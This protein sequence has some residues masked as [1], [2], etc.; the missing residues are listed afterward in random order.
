MDDFDK[1]NPEPDLQNLLMHNT[2]QLLGDVMLN[3]LLESLA[4]GVVIINE[5]GRIVLINKRFAQLTGYGKQEVIGQSLSIF[6]PEGMDQKHEQDISDYFA[7]PRIRPLG[8]DLNLIA[9]R[10]D[11]SVFPVEISLSHL[12]TGTED[13]G[14]AFITDISARKKAEEELLTRNQELDAYARNVAHDLN[15]PLA[16]LINFSDLLLDSDFEIS[17]EERKHYLEI[18]AEDSRKMSSIIKELLIFATIKKEDIRLSTVHMKEP[19][20]NVISR[21]RFQIEQKSVQLK[22]DKNICD[23]SGYGPWIEEVWFNYISNAIRYGGTPPLIE[24]GSE[25]QNSD[26][27]KYFVKDNGSGVSTEFKEI[28]FQ[29]NNPE[30]D[31]AAHGYGLGLSIV[32]SIVEKLGGYVAVESIEGNGSIFSFYLKKAS[33]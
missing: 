5:R 33:V 2:G 21:L 27:I 31:K 25:V 1:I 10:K 26:F 8:A 19:I 16:S 32:K 6:L 29:T 11:N 24:I 14:I 3:T 18:I 4:E 30:K 17:D 22:I 28:A 9:K 13:L 23:C 12:K 7:K 15:T 20:E